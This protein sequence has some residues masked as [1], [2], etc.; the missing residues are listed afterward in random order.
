MTFLIGIDVGGTNTDSVL[1]DPSQIRSSNSGI[2]NWSKVT[3]T[4]EISHGIELSLSNLLE[5][6]KIGPDD[7]SCVTIGT[8]HFINAIVEKDQGKLE[9]VAI[10]RLC[11][12]YSRELPPF[13]DFPKRLEEIL[14]GYV[15]Y[16][17]GGN[18]IDTLDITE[19]DEKEITYHCLKIAELGITNIAVVGMFSP[20]ANGHELRVYNII[21]ENF[22]K[23][24]MHVNVTLSHQIA[25]IGF[26]ERENITI[27]NAAI[28]RYA[29]SVIYE[30]SS[31]VKRSQFKCPL[32]LT[33]NDGT[34]LTVQEALKNPIRTF[35]S[36]V[37]NSMRGASY[38]CKSEDLFLNELDRNQPVVVVDI[39]G[40][41]T[42][43]GLLNQDGFPN[44][45]SSY[46]Y[47]GG[48]RTK[49]PMPNVQSI[50]LGGGSIVRSEN[51]KLKIGPD[52]VGNEIMNKAMAFDGSC[53]TATDLA[54]SLIAERN[55]KKL[56]NNFFKFVDV[57]KLKKQ[58]D[59]DMCNLFK[60]ELVSLLSKLID[61]TKTSPDQI[62][63]L[64]VGGGS[65]IVPEGP[66]T[67]EGCNRILR[68]QFYQIANAIGAAIGLISES[69]SLYAN[70]DEVDKISEIERLKRL[71]LKEA[72]RKGALPSSLKVVNI[73][74]EPVPYVSNCYF[75]EVKVVGSLDYSRKSEL[76]EKA[77]DPVLKGSAVRQQD[78][79]SFLK[80]A[81]IERTEPMC[82]LDIKLYKP[83]ITEKREWILSTLDIEFIRIGSYI[84]GCGGG[85][86]PYTK[87]LQT[88]K[89]IESGLVIKVVDIDGIPGIFESPNELLTV[90]LAACGS[91]TVISEQLQGHEFLHAF[92]TLIRHSNLKPNAVIPLEIGG[93]NGFQAFLLSGL[94]EYDLKV[95]DADL[96][97]RAYPMIWQISP[98][99]YKDVLGYSNIFQNSSLSDGNGNDFLLSNVK[100][101]LYAEKIIRA[102]LSEVGSYVGMATSPLKYEELKKFSIRNSISLAW[103]I[104]RAVTLAKDSR[105]LDTVPE[106]I[107]N[108]IGGS[109]YGRLIFSGKIVGLEKKLI[110]GHLYGEV[111][112]EEFNSSKSEDKK[113]LVIPFK[114]ENLFCKY[115]HT[116]CTEIIASVPELITVIDSET[117]EA[118]G[119]P[120]Y[121]Y[122]LSCFV[123]VM[124]PNQIWTSSKNALRIGGPEAFGF[125]HFEF[126]STFQVESSPRSVI[127]EYFIPS[128]HATSN[129]KENLH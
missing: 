79:R 83:S 32:F 97:G 99:L 98:V 95:V 19:V 111:V 109:D 13:S 73:I 56:P 100:S 46:S 64:L 54:L 57:K 92:K 36:G 24:K 49:I 44:L 41:T 77:S 27:L 106:F 38:L 52:S 68:P 94:Y 120:D 42:D 82:E 86:D 78:I 40:T 23:R 58:F 84:L 34:I 122:G 35:S 62:S 127:D 93:S 43:A 4:N 124:A 85:G 74:I 60:N 87:A 2:I 63:M 25:G 112:I 119:T 89:M 17:K 103:R 30:F 66:F 102:T 10:L 45:I 104:G 16:C 22:R 70:K 20:V 96:M 90:P 80:K 14:N 117:G 88:K 53:M 33:Q 61:R 21:K 47:I 107:I 50:G 121:R 5:G 128:I 28:K 3:T 26:L 55:L 31:A 91:P 11:G 6:Q 115:E 123:I 65:F 101:E 67:I 118:I 1:L 7:I 108:A 15:A 110:K 12:P 72:V 105:N 125:D 48:V 126:K 114:N 69:V 75:F 113:K 129:K 59:D 76:F 18:K 37:T 39:G 71:A 29:Y 116:P 51:S 8:T 81:G 9:K